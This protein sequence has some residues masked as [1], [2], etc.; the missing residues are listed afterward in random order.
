LPAIAT[1]GVPHSLW[2]F[3]SSCSF[4]PLIDGDLFCLVSFFGG[5][6]HGRWP[7]D[8]PFCSFVPFDGGN[9]SVGPIWWDYLSWPPGGNFSPLLTYSLVNS[10]W[11]PFSTST[12]GWLT[13]WR[14]AVMVWWWHSYKWWFDRRWWLSIVWPHYWQRWLW[15]LTTPVGDDPPY[16]RW[17]LTRW[18]LAFI[19]FDYRCSATILLW[20]HFGR[21]LEI[22]EDGVRWWLDVRWNSFCWVHSPPPFSLPAWIRCDCWKAYDLLWILPD[23][24][25]VVSF[26]L[27]GAFTVGSGIHHWDILG[28][29]HY[30][31][32]HWSLRQG[33]LGFCSMRDGCHS[34]IHDDLWWW[35]PDDIICWW[36]HYSWLPFHYIMA[37]LPDDDLWYSSSRSDDL[38]MTWPRRRS[39]YRYSARYRYSLQYIITASRLILS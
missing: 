23:Y 34:A 22:L 31:S 15:C 8:Y 4:I 5:I 18:Y 39:R 9:A 7:G 24:A 27:L 32:G 35:W 28:Y 37:T 16:G 10:F 11:S 29:S 1:I 12:F 19:R 3:S 17:F 38:S 21:W 14:P 20:F 30:R 26:T 2:T 33:P 13:R 36:R 6:F 25:T